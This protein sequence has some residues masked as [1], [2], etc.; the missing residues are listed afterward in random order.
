MCNPSRCCTGPHPFSPRPD[1]AL[2]KNLLLRLGK[3]MIIAKLS[4]M[5][6]TPDLSRPDS[7]NLNGLGKDLLLLAGII[8]MFFL[9]WPDE[10]A[11]NDAESR[12]LKI[13]FEA[14]TG[15]AP[16]S[17]ALIAR[18]EGAEKTFR[19]SAEIVVVAYWDGVRMFREEDNALEERLAKLADN[20]VDFIV[21]QQSL[22]D[23]EMSQ[24]DL[25]AFTRTVRSGS[26]EAR[27]LEKQGWA[28]VPDG[29]SYVSPL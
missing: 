9:L 22:T 13:A 2:W 28:R 15:S 8:A 20:G 24:S 12:T 4:R 14:T 19:D 27:R 23:A 17:E 29:D 3:G 25:L 26:E 11:G 18:I 21:C 5:Q 6:L 7:S 10:S 1:C 16:A